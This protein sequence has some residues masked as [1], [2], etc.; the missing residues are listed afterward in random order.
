M[1]KVQN[2]IAS[3]MVVSIFIT[4]NALAACTGS[5]PTWTTTPDYASVNSCVSQAI[6]G[7]TINVSAGSATWSS[8]I[9]VNKPVSI[10]GAGKTN[11]VLTAS[12]A[13]GSDRESYAGGFFWITS[14]NSSTLARISGFRFEMTNSTPLIGIKVSA[15]GVT[16]T[17]IRIDNNY[18]NQGQI[19]ILFAHM[20]G[21]IDNNDFYNWNNERSISL[22]AGS[23]TNADASWSDMSAG[24]ANGVFIEN[25]NFVLNEGY[26]LAYAAYA[27]DFYQ[28]GKYAI[29][30]NNFDY[31]AVSK[32]FELMQNHGSD[33]GYW[34][35]STIVR[36]S[37]AI[38][39]IYNNT[40]KAY[41]LKWFITARGGSIIVHSNSVVSP[42]YSTIN[43]KIYEE[44]YTNYP[45]YGPARANWPAEDQVHNSFFWNNKRSGTTITGFSV[46]HQSNAVCTGVGTS[47]IGYLGCCTGVGTGNCDNTLVLGRDYFAHAPCGAADTTDGYGNSCTHGKATFTGANGASGSYPTDGITYPTK[48]TMVF[49]ATGDNAYLDYTPYTYPH[50]LRGATTISGGVSISGGTIQ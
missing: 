24:T 27:F 20:K 31:S 35:T 15:L 30:Y 22:S 1:N 43:A 16:S 46:L 3:L 7:D 34:Q 44:E 40:I 18:F 4:G 41:G 9:T 17:N 33:F 36:R 32:V 39:E 19:Q 48:G 5:S 29:R 38:I 26:T 28:G 23:R 13:M 12:G 50:P 10:I 42:N 6:A 2:L 49:T 25:N 21:L 11:T 37:P 14:F 45:E 8:S 47:S